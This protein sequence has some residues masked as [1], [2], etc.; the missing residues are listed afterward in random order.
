M[1]E[2]D[3]AFRK[4]F[5]GRSGTRTLTRNEELVKKYI[6]QV[7]VLSQLH[8]IVFKIMQKRESGV[9]S[10]KKVES[11]RELA[12]EYGDMTPLANMKSS[13]D[14]V[15]AEEGNEEEDD[16]AEVELADE[17]EGDDMSHPIS[18]D[19]NGDEAPSSDGDAPNGLQSE[20]SKSKS[21]RANKCTPL[22]ES[23]KVKSSKADVP[24][25]AHETAAP[26]AKRK[27]PSESKGDTL[28]DLLVKT[29]EVFLEKRGR[30]E[31]NLSETFKTLRS[32]QNVIF[33]LLNVNV[34]NVG[35][36]SNPDEQNEEQSPASRVASQGAAERDHRT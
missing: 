16:E 14:K 18:T 27:N 29:L 24:G 17:H 12:H 15:A 1:F 20:R 11:S 31:G 5:Q 9:E 2:L 26:R 28:M 22:K 35:N 4:K 3:K 13:G 21:A 30:E 8:C 36:A 6:D 32:N 25:E 19:L 7:C 10:K 23:V 33:T 34:Q